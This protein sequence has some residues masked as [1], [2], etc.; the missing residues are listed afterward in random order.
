MNIRKQIRKEEAA[1]RQAE[2][3]ALSIE[4]KIAR[5][6]KRRGTS[7]KELVRLSAQLAATKSQEA[8]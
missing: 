3:N 1:V 5:A 2:Y 8:A 6:A 4:Q 7:R